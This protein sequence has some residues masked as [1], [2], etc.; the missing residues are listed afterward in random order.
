MV[1][2]SLDLYRS[3]LTYCLNCSR[4]SSKSP[5]P[6]GTSC[7]TMYYSV[8]QC[9][10]T[11]CVLQCVA[12]HPLVRRVQCLGGGSE[13]DNGGYVHQLHLGTPMLTHWVVR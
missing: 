9:V 3:R 13:W 2:V 4:R 1:Q 10:A 12:T 6:A 7:G 8:L 11:H 5:T